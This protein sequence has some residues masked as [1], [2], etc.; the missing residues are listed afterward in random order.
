MIESSKIQQQIQAALLEAQKRANNLKVR[1]LELEL[2]QVQD[3]SRI[4]ASDFIPKM[5][6]NSNVEAL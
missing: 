5:G 4:M 6:V 3:V 1:E 2:K